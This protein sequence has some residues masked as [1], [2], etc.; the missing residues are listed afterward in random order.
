MTTEVLE[1]RSTFGQLFAVSAYRMVFVSRSLAIA[2]DTLR[3]IA[4][5]I[6]VYSLTRS[7]FLS[8][9]TFGI[10]FLPQVA[11]G[12][13]F[14]SLADRVRPRRLITTGYLVECA[15]ALCLATVP[16]PVGVSLAIVAAVGAFMPVFGGAS[17]RLIAEVLPGDLYVLGR[18]ASNMAAGGAQLLGMAFGGL[19]VAA[20]GPQRALLISAAAHAV[21]ALIVR[22]GLSDMDAPPKATELGAVKESWRTNRAL[23]KDSVIRALLLIQWLPPLFIVGAEALIVAYADARGFAA[24][25]AGLL[26]AWSPAGMLVGHL[27]VG[28]FLRPETRT[29]LVAP[30]IVLL[31]APTLALAFSPPQWMVGAVLFLTGC[32]FG[33]PLGLQRVFVDAIPEHRRG[34]AFGLLTMGLMTFQGT[35]PLIFGGIA[36]VWGIR[37][38]MALAATAC[39]STAAVWWRRGR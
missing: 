15:A 33:Y 32:G 24:G 25:S 9:V 10:G 6:L 38:A 28:R 34:Q 13:L 16:M 29:R 37:A 27:V 1:K 12:M 21:S 18:S 31:G 20:A 17:A 14:G 36:Q 2:A 8:A 4:L 35:G 19:A 22:F 7:A 23:L 39:V 5:S 11:G 3:I 26:L 30:L